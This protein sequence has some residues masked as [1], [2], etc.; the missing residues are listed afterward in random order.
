V[1]PGSPCM[2][3]RWSPSLPP[4][5]PPLPSSSL[6]SLVEESLLKPK[7]CARCPEA[8][9]TLA[10]SYAAMTRGKSQITK[11]L[12]PFTLF[13]L[14]LMDEINVPMATPRRKHP[15]CCALERPGKCMCVSALK[16][17][18]CA[19]RAPYPRWTAPA[20]DATSTTRVSSPAVK[21]QVP[22]AVCPGIVASTC[23][24]AH[25]DTC[26]LPCSSRGPN[27]GAWQVRLAATSFHARG[28]NRQQSVRGASPVL[29]IDMHVEQKHTARPTTGCSPH[30][31]Q[32][33]WQ[34]TR[35]RRQ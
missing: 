6:S 13:G 29:I 20:T 2:L 28:G 15:F 22:A 26:T 16:G 7:S 19:V 14:R 10:R 27:S 33:A 21:L 34:Q 3:D 23:W 11:C 35:C 12:E 4:L 1:S 31:L 25:T 9:T 18:C 30:Q 5:P 32:L 24:H 17:R 8:R